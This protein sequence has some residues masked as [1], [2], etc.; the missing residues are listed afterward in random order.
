[1]KKLILGFFAV[2]AIFTLPAAA[3]SKKDILKNAA[4]T[5]DQVKQMLVLD[6]K[7]VNYP[8]YT[9]RK[10]WD[11][12]LGDWKQIYIDR[13]VKCLEYKWQVVPVTT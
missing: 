13:G 11:E 2:M 9:D 10:G 5:P 12:F 6:Q 1:M 8:D 7:W 4:G 3:Y